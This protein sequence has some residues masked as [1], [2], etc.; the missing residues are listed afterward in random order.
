MSKPRRM[1]IRRLDE[2]SLVDRPA[3]P[4]ATIVLTKRAPTEKPVKPEA[5][6]EQ[7][8]GWVTK[9]LQALGIKKRVSERDGK[10][11]AFDEE[12]KE[13]GA[14]D[15]KEQAEA[16]A[17]GK[18]QE[19]VMP[20]QEKPE[21]EVVSKAEVEAITK[22]LTERLEKAEADAKIEKAARTAEFT[23]RAE[24]YKPLPIADG[25]GAILMKAADALTTEENAE[26]DRVL[27]AASEAMRQSGIMKEIGSGAPEEGTAVAEV[28]KKVEELRKQDPK[29]TE[30][31]ARAKV[32]K[33]NPE[34]RRK[35]EAEQAPQGR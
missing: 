32:Y 21:A 22:A 3:N 23:K 28:A 4:L 16:R 34:L 27:S 2:F 29:L 1:R 18:R 20:E 33:S 7:V 19:K 25:F 10:W 8:V 11:I 26:L 6:E 13:L 31:A 17:Y 24:G 9:A 15:S 14:F 12:G 30:Q 5:T 35:V